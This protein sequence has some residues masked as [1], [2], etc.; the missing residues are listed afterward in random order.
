MSFQDKYMKALNLEEQ[1]SIV[2][3]DWITDSIEEGVKLDEIE[4]HPRL[5]KQPKSQGMHQTP[6]APRAKK[7][8]KPIYLQQKEEVKKEE[9]KP[10]P[11]KSLFDTLHFSDEDDMDDDSETTKGMSLLDQLKTPQTWKQSTTKH[12]A[13]SRMPASSVASTPLPEAEKSPPPPST[14]PNV[15]SS[16]PSATGSD[17]FPPATSPVKSVL[18]SALQKRI[19]ERS[20]EDSSQMV[21][22]APAAPPVAPSPPVSNYNS[23]ST[24]QPDEATHILPSL[25]G[26]P[27]LQDSPLSSDMASNDHSVTTSSPSMSAPPVMGSTGIPAQSKCKVM[28]PAFQFC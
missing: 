14:Q 8:K 10:D 20:P 2:T 21:D 22:P 28:F 5:L 24:V 17:L 16:L 9:K 13:T 27:I 23:L 12:S 3:P 25:D 26:Q 11:Q 19:E 1:I 15:A 18:E 6:V 7:K 4:Y